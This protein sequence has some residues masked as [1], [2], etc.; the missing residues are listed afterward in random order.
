MLTPLLDAAESVITSFFHTTVAPNVKTSEDYCSG[1]SAFQWMARSV[2]T[3]LLN[4][5]TK[6]FVRRAIHT[7]DNQLFELASTED[8]YM[9]SIF[10]YPTCAARI[11]PLGD[12]CPQ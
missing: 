7:A 11:R 3:I 5:H 6:D 12:R 10:I 2:F 1:A 9:E 8:S 4:D